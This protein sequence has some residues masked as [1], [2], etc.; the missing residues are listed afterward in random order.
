[1]GKVVHLLSG[2]LDSTVLLYDLLWN[3]YDVL[4]CLFVDYGQAQIQEQ[5]WAEYHAKWHGVPFRKLVL[6]ELSDGLVVVP[7]RNAIFLG[8]AV[9]RAVALGADWVT[10]GANED[11]AVTFPDCRKE[12]V[13]TF[14]RL[15]EASGYRVRVL[16]PFMMMSKKQV[17]ELG[18][19]LGV[20]M[21]R[22]W[23]C[24]AGGAS[25]CGECLACK[26]RTEAEQCSI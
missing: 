5:E 3:G 21:G 11:D 1:M 24:Y 2:G 19:E 12:F 8:C 14:N 4:E 16:P 15:I 18:K 13:G 23:T 26:T 10:F 6:P 7:M 17:V 20:E 22:T 9:N 25:P